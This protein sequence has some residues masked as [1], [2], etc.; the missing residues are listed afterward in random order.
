MIMLGGLALSGQT[1]EAQYYGTPSWVISG[2]LNNL[3]SAM[4][5]NVAATTG[6]ASQIRS[7]RMEAWAYAERDYRF[8]VSQTP[9]AVY[10][11]PDG[12]VLAAGPRRVTVMADNATAGRPDRLKILP[13]QSVIIE[14]KE[15]PVC[16]LE[17]STDDFAHPMRYRQ[18]ISGNQVIARF[19]AAGYTEFTWFPFQDKFKSLVKCDGAI[20]GTKDGGRHVLVGVR[21]V[22]E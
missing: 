12:E 16:S 17:L 20:L 6:V 11:G 22:E 3:Q 2:Q 13:E 21:V 5:A 19:E 15:L 14:G 10:Y 9:N 8:R 4:Q 18:H 1:A 7:S